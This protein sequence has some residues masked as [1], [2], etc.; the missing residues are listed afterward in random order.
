MLRTMIAAGAA[1][2]LLGSMAT[3]QTRSAAK[4]CAADIETHCGKFRPGG[5]EISECV[6][7]HIKDFSQKCQAAMLQA[8]A[9]AKECADDI[10]QTCAGVKRGG[11]RIEAC[12][13]AHLTDI[14]DGCKGAI[15]GTPGGRI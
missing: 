14:S 7:T 15:S 1:L 9:T 11:G 3:A 12:L 8:K 13:H 4:A 6:K 5:A 2:M 10:K